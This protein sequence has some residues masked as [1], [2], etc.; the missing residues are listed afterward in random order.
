MTHLKPSTFT[1][2]L[3]EEPDY[4]LRYLMAITGIG[5]LFEYSTEYSSGENLY[6][7]S[8]NH[9]DGSNFRGMSARVVGCVMTSA[10]VRLTA[11]LST[12]GSF[13]A[14][15]HQAPLWSLSGNRSQRRSRPWLE[16]WNNLTSG[17]FYYSHASLTSREAVR[18]GRRA[19]N[20]VQV[21]HLSIDL[22]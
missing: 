11:K 16:Y 8:P 21:P 17:N 13:A 3:G 9:D 12:S 15:R 14:R 2:N 4:C 6:S 7:R 10:L 1:T 18:V 19:H 20:G 22:H 5:R